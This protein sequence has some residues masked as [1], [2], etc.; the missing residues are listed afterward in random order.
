MSETRLVAAY[1]RVS[2]D[3]Q[4][5]SGTIESQIAALK[6]RI[7]VNGEQIAEDMLFNGR[8]ECASCHDVHN[9]FNNDELLLK[10]NGGSGLCLTCHNK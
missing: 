9:A 2:S 7:S 10:P 4:A 5:K 8:M 6:E 1:A 3:Q